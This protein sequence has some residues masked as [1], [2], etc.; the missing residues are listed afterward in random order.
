[1]NEFRKARSKDSFDLDE[2][3]NVKVSISKP[4]FRKVT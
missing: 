2:A 3:R 4:K 1:V